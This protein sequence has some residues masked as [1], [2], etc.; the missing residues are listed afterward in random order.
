MVIQ[1]HPLPEPLPTITRKSWLKILGVSLHEKPG[2]G[3]FTL[4]KL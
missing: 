4:M 3:T 2:I 1:K